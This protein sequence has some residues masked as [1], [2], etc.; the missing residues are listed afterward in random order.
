MF[1]HNTRHIAALLLLLSTATLPQTGYAASYLETRTTVQKTK[2]IATLAE[3]THGDASR[4]THTLD[5]RQPTLQLYFDLPPAE[6]T[7]EIILTL[8][9][10]PLTPVASNAPLQI[11]FNN[12]KP[13]SVFSKGRGF[14]ARIPL[15]TG[16]ARDRRNSLR[17]IYPTPKGTD[18]IMP[19]HGKWSVDLSASTLRMSGRARNRNMSLIEIKKYLTSPS[20]AP[21]KVG[22]IAHGPNGT[23]MQAL[24]A[25]G[26]SLRG[27][28]VPKFSVTTRGNDFNIVMVKRDRLLKVT[29]DPMIV[30]SKG[31]RIF[32]AKGRPTS[33]IFT[34]D[35]D[36]E[37][38]QMLEIFSTR[39]LPNTSRPIASIGEL[40]LQNQLDQ[41]VVQIKKKAALSD[42]GA[43]QST[44][45]FRSDNWASGTQTYRFGVEDPI[46]TK[47]EL[48]LRLSTTNDVANTS[49]LRVALNGEVLGAAKLDRKRKSVAFDIDAGK[50]NATSNFLSIL[51]ELDAKPGYTCQAQNLGTPSFTLDQGSS[52]TLKQDT[53]SPIT[54]LSRLAATGGIFAKAESYIV[55][56]LETRD[57]Q[58]ALG[59]LGQM[60]KSA[61]HGLTLADYTRKDI[62]VSDKHV[63]VIGP[64]KLAQKYTASAPKAL[65]EALKGSAATGKNLLASN[66][67][68]FANSGADDFAVQF[69]A[70]QMKP[71]RI[72]RGGVAA[73]YGSGRGK[74]TGIISSASGDSFIR[75]SHQLTQIAH[76][77]ALRGGVS[78]WDKS[79][80]VM[81]Q[82]AQ[83]APGVSEPRE[84][85]ELSFAGIDFPQIQWPDFDMPKVSLSK[86]N[87]P[88][89]RT[90][91]KPVKV[92]TANLPRD[93]YKDVKPAKT[94]K[95]LEAPAKS[96]K[97]VSV[98]PRVK[99]SLVKASVRPAS[100]RGKFQFETPNTQKAASL[101]DLKRSTK[102]KWNA[103]KQWSKD[104]TSGLKR[105]DTLDDIAQMTDKLQDKV[106]PVGQ[107]TRQS[108]KQNMPGKGL[109]KLADRTISANGI[110]LMLA[111]AV[112]LLL[113][114]IA[115]P[116]SRL[117]GRH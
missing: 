66:I 26:I 99:P 77:N 31:A 27:P 106:K 21:K 1:H 112:F 107:T 114:S 17:I 60:A 19:S 3:I 6:R 67:E 88:T 11:Q 86:L 29:N 108:I 20:L 110:I 7:T 38:L 46:A 8:S 83:P 54:E 111:L 65:R 39:S 85:R 16:I 95:S 24:A 37:I 5:W 91:E 14:E 117:G 23:D 76:W 58:A 90:V 45:N 13:V 4:T 104:K 2:H 116:T 50:L 52:L 49:R 64:T 81:A 105:I 72:Q 101:Q 36:A 70:A 63:L 94:A 93:I 69:A 98:E 78:R 12:E 43:G 61:G 9:A 34:A 103:A 97:T 42:L 59:V 73:L 48:L 40:N 62:Q 33:L 109:I 30:N 35:T 41:G 57:Y 74:L 89:F 53:K 115:K 32:V 75:T 22:L 56:P 100:L 25:Q 15:D 71:R 68:R 28:R 51:P 87:W 47:A 44:I 113:M 84:N 102:V 10:D 82:T 55:L 92:Q 79:S 96:F 18:C 80:V